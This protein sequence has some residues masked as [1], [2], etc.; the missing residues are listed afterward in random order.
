MFRC[1]TESNSVKIWI[2]TCDPVLPEPF[3]FS[4]FVASVAIVA[5]TYAI[6]KIKRN[7]TELKENL[8]TP[9]IYIIEY[10]DTNWNEIIA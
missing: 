10:K 1:L 4:L 9:G 5:I 3:F 8:D 6:I 7:R 2:G